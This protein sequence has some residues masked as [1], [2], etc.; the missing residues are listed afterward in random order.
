MYA[1]N[2]EHKTGNVHRT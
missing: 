2:N 1:S